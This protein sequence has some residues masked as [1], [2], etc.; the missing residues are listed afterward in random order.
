MDFSSFPVGDRGQHLCGNRHYVN[1]LAPLLLET[2]QKVSYRL[3]MA[4]F[5]SESEVSLCDHVNCD[6]DSLKILNPIP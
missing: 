2:Q 4:R 6:K 1:Y 3:I 5:I